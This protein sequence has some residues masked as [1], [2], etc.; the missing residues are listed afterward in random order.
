V[1]S[2]AKAA[3]GAS[4]L[5]S[6]SRRRQV[7][8]VS[9]LASLLT[10]L[11]IAAPT[12]AATV[13]QRPLLFTF[14]GSDTTAG[15]L[16]SVESIAVDNATGAVYVGEGEGFAEDGKAVDRFHPDGTA[17][18]FLATGQSSLV[19]RANGSLVSG[20]FG[21]RL[22]VAV[23]NS[24]GST[25]SRLYVANDE[26]RWLQALDPSGTNLWGFETSFLEPP[27]DVAV[28]ASGHPWLALAGHGT[29]EYAS[30]GSPPA[31][32]GSVSVSAQPFDLDSSGNFFFHFFG[33]GIQKWTGESFDS[34][35]D[36]TGRDVY[37]DQSSPSGHIFT[38]SGGRNESQEFTV[39]AT[40]GQYRLSFG[41]DQTTDLPF[42]AGAEQVKAAL[43]ALP[44]VGPGN[45]WF[46]SEE[47]SGSH[48][49]RFGFQNLLSHADLEPV[50]CEDGTTPLSGGSGCSVATSEQGESS[51]FNEYAANGSQLGSFG[52]E[53][54]D[55][56]ASV[57]Y[58]PG[59]DRVYVADGG[60]V[61]GNSDDSSIEA[62]GHPYIA[63]FGPPQ[64]GTVADVSIEAPSSVGVSEATFKGTVNPQGTASEWRF[65][66]RRP[67]QSWLN[68]GS[69]PA[70]SLP[71][72]SS[73][74]AVEF[75]TNALRGDSAYQVRL[76][77]V[78]TANKLSGISEPEGFLTTKA[79]AAPVV[80]ID[81]P[82]AVTA[83]T[84]K[85]TGTVNP[86]GDTADW[87]VQTS[88]DPACVEGFED[89]P[90]QEITSGSSSPVPVEYEVTGLLASEHYCA[91]IVATNSAGG[92]TSE[93][94]EFET[95]EAAPTQVFTAYAAP[96]TDTSAR[97][98]GYLNPE[99][100][101]ADY[102]LEYSQDGSDWT[103]LPTE[104]SS[105][106]R[107]QIVV[108]E[109]VSG[110]TP[111]TTYHYRFVTENGA[112]REE[113]E[114]KT[115]TTRTSA[116]MQPPVRGIELVNNP[117]KGNQ[118]LF[119]LA[120]AGG[121]VSAD[122][123]KALWSVTAGAPGGN[124]G[125]NANFLATRTPSGWVSKPLIPPAEEQV[126]GG[127]LSYKLNN[128][129]P[130]FRHFVLRAFQ[131]TAG[132][133][134]APT[135]V[136]LDD[137][138]HQNVLQAIHTV[139]ANEQINTGTDITDDGSHVLL[140]NYETGEVED[141]SGGTP[142]VVSIMPDGTPSE[143]PI[144]YYQFTGSEGQYN[145]GAQW[146]SGYHRMAS[147]DA[148]RVYFQGVPN[149]Q[150][151]DTGPKAIFFRDRDA[152]QTIEVDPGSAAIE[153]AMIRATPDGRS[154]YFITRTSH[155][156]EDTNGAPDIYRWDAE[157]GSYACLTCIV[158]DPRL[159]LT[160]AQ[161]RPESILVS[162]DFSHIYFLS[163]G[164]LMPG[165]G[166]AGDENAYVLRDGSL[167][168]VADLGNGAQGFSNGEMSADG[169]VLVWLQEGK[170]ENLT[171]DRLTGDCVG[172]PGSQPDCAQ[173]YR[174]EDSSE[175]LECISCAP[176][177][178]TKNRA[179]TTLTL[180]SAQS[181]DGNTTAFV[182]RE[183]LVPQDINGTYDVYEWRNGMVRLVSDGETVF[184]TGGVTLPAV[185][186]IDATGQNVF[187]WLIDRGLTGYEHDGFSN[188]YDARIGGG[189]P[190]P[191]EP[192]HCSE[193]SCQG[194]LQ[195]P[196]G[197]PSSG[198]SGLAGAGNVA[199]VSKGRCAAK[200]GRARSRCLHKNKRHHSKHKRHGK[201]R[202]A[203]TNAGGA[204]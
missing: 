20:P 61:D 175:S 185:Y 142:E 101:E 125:T 161:A 65:E 178:P 107:R 122:G 133:D 123:N 148:S 113:G 170:V 55:A 43:E 179:G 72:D 74:H 3:S 1:R 109:E 198:S 14:N 52:S 158:T 78:N 202:A 68:G 149:G 41:G 147:T 116:E 163:T 69:S 22:F 51:H 97:L 85:I 49:F 79:A 45:I 50:G 146:R 15:P 131:S 182:T 73:D 103:A 92:T 102:W 76:V 47:P 180:V 144:P 165:Y 104:Q 153:S 120:P 188:L 157:G 115:F 58:D 196:P 42:D 83:H 93:A 184:P 160:G 24:G 11:F 39:D 81:A 66:W 132:H 183:A 9:L 167:G 193:E 71:T 21:V 140:G 100:S 129:T 86:E 194:P 126:G 59:L 26:G 108:G 17:W 145:S 187:F 34:T 89:Q 191:E 56:G 32:I 168:F 10:L 28:D 2:H 13:T 44:S 90:L 114:E 110:L 166:E 151:C 171:A 176:G 174:Y 197:Q 98:N 172:L 141:I 35:I 128:V 37:V 27:K 152:E 138:Q 112:G 38:V 154:L 62:G 159:V 29:H 143:C 63:A 33:E 4:D 192:E 6:A 204:K 139:G 40:A 25:Q 96:R 95:L 199:P 119:G 156:G 75:T 162:D 12:F 155:V 121:R 91:R 30:S 164:Q 31:E 77:A 16:T 8:A 57:A 53:Y 106:A 189:F 7:G 130:D 80:T 36:P 186:G 124:S 203:K 82:S 70:Q 60:G 118:N 173:F 54:L 19:D 94:K 201:K 111:S 46:V 5:D 135:Y 169:N 136:R 67:G 64:T 18:P 127:A 137:E 177:R 117:D 150:P 200:K 48:Q 195:A 190:R 84:A 99:G 105:E 87:R 88:T 181:A 23:D 134:G